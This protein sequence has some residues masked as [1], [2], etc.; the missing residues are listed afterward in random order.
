MIITLK[1]ADFS[2]SNIGTLSSWRIT[3][4]LGTGATY[5]G[6][7][8]VDK[9]ASF[10]ATITIA[11]GYELGAAGVTVTMGGTAISAAIVNGNIITITITEVTGNVV[12]KVPTVNINTGE[13]DEPDTPDVPEGL[14]LDSIALDGRTYEEIFITNN[15]APD[16]CNNSMKNSFGNL[17]YSDSTGTTSIVTD[18]SSSPTFVA[19]YSLKV[20]GSTS[21]QAKC[22]T[23]Y[24]KNMEYF[25]ACNVKVTE[26]VQGKC[27][28]IFG[29]NGACATGL[30]ND[31]EV[32]TVI[33]SSPETSGTD[34]NLFIGS[35]SSANLTGYI[36]N[37]VVVR[38]ELF[39]TKPT[40]EELTQAYKNYCYILKANNQ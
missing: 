21:Q 33:R 37:P 35:A 19:P 13:E 40:L 5:D 15:R 25:L 38:M 18:T 2:A 17:T 24:S 6:V 3:R 36:N 30:T 29:S 34:A 16:I 27:G 22:S 10:T 12:I 14:T 11:E 23:K 8:S 32:F 4:S 7:T 20:A 26:Y 28:M 1:G 31:Y 39:T 9:G